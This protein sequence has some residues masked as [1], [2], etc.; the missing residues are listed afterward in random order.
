MPGLFV[1]NGGG[2][3]IDSGDLIAFLHQYR[4]GGPDRS[5]GRGDD[6]AAQTT[7]RAARARPGMDRVTGDGSSVRDGRSE[8]LPR[9]LATGA[10]FDR[11]LD[12]VRRIGYDDEFIRKWEFFLAGWYAMFK[13]GHYN[14]MQAKLVHYP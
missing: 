2:E 7:G 12:D 10:G 1:W 8:P 13:S 6:G 5:P 14:V 4:A 3:G 11:N 9:E